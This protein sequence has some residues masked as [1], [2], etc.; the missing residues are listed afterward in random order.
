MNEESI[1]QSSVAARFVKRCFDIVVSVLFVCTFFP[2]I[3]IIVGVAIKLDS[4]GP[5]FF[6][7][8]RTG[9][10]GKPFTCLKFRT[11]VVNSNADVEQ[12]T[13]EDRRIT[14]VGH[15]L[16]WASIDELP[17]FLHVLVGTMSV[18]GPRPHMVYH[19][20]YYTQ[21]IP[22]YERRL[23]V[24]PGV[25]GLAQITGF[26]GATPEDIDMAHRVRMDVWYIRH[27]SFGLDLY[28]FFKTIGKFWE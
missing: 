12:S 15:F 1:L 22:G 17:Q 25:T 4:P 19:T 2:I 26:R 28:I 18:I 24:K 3:C 13:A 7:Q 14:K 6:R 11:M 27:W 5:I 23:V 10:D 9:K 21:R 16:R 8:R 20:D